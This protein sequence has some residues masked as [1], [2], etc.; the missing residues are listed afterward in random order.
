MLEDDDLALSVQILQEFYV[1]A[2]TRGAK[3]DRRSC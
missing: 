1:Q 3:H 2:A